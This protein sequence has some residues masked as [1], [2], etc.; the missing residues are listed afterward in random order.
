MISVND[1]NDTEMA[2]SSF[3]LCGFCESCFDW[4]NFKLASFSGEESFYFN[5][6]PNTNN[7]INDD[8]DESCIELNKRDDRRK[9]GN[10]NNP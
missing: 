3:F 5:D 1:R 9:K 8:N 10:N 2:E 4:D 6:N 7:N